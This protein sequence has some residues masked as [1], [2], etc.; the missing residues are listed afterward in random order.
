M[1]RIFLMVTL[2]LALSAPGLA[3]TSD[4]DAATRD[5]IILYLRTM[6]SHDLMQRTM[7]VQ[8]QSIQQLMHDQLLQEKGTIP[9]EFDA[10]M[11]KMMDELRKG[12]PV[13]EIIDAMIPAYQNHFT[14]S[15]VQAMNAFYSSPVGQ[16]VLEQLP[17]VM[18][19]GMQAAMPIMNKYLTEWKDRMA[20]DVKE[21]D[22]S[23]PQKKVIPLQ[24]APAPPAQ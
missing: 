4:T 13:D 10:H 22:K 9:P 23:S 5:D 6:R 18:Q 14:R 19:E 20:Q 3:Q 2:C 17:A 1:M 16:K 8:F 11:K 15:D 21:L 12:M 24:A 7:E